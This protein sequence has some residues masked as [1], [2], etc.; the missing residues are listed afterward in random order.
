MF[1]PNSIIFGYNSLDYLLIK[2]KE[3]FSL[4]GKD[5]FLLE[6]TY[7]LINQYEDIYNEFK[8]QNLCAWS[9]GNSFNNE[10]ECLNFLSGQMNY[11]YEVASFALHDLI[12]TGKNI[13]EYFMK[14]NLDIVG[15]LSEF[16]K[17]NYDDI[18]ENQVFRLSLFN[19]NTIHSDL[20]VLFTQS[21]LPYITNLINDT[22]N[23]IIDSFENSDSNYY[24]YLVCYILFNLFIYLIVWIP[25]IKNMN[26]VI[27]NSKK[28]L[29]I[30]PIHV[31][32]T[33]V[34]I[35]KILNLER[36]KDD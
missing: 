25:F 30:I 33:L 2:D 7:S 12:F 32:T 16:G 9:S 8:K 10:D 19:N 14:E 11:G 3:I 20:N 6:T 15:N 13:I 22:S 1:D 18:L 24:I 35:K 4:N 28:I 27:Y 36:E 5:N 29:G 23:F 31:L 34:N 17:N 26:S 21:L